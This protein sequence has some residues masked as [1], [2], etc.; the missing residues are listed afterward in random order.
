MFKQDAFTLIAGPCA[1]E[2]FEQLETIAKLLNKL[3]IKHL[4]GGAFKPRTSPYD[5]QGHGL[6]ALKWLREVADRYQLK[7]VTEALSTQTLPAVIEHAD[8]IQVGS[9][10]M[11]NSALLTAI[12]QAT[13]KPVLLKRGMSA[14]Y[15]EWLLAAEYVASAGNS[16]LILCERGIRSFEPSCRNTLDLA[17]VPALQAESDYPIIVDPSHGTGRPDLII[18]MTRAACACGAQGAMIEIHPQPD[19]ALSDG[20]QALTFPELID[21]VEQLDPLAKACHRPLA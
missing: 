1:V 5:F 8:I 7:V 11:H 21:L 9:R 10:N 17:A 12:G 2:S 15:R 19:Q 3:N 6:K 16:N 4:R 18:P 20:H 13:Q 14:T